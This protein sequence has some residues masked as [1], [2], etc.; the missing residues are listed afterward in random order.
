[1]TGDEA[2]ASAELLGRATRRR[3]RQLG[4]KQQELADLA[5]VSVRFVHDLEHGKA[6]VQ[7]AQV[8]LVLDALG[9][10]VSIAPGSGPLITTHD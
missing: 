7:L 6:T 4:L 9:L 2:R 10:H 8:L 5:E 1:M 3:R